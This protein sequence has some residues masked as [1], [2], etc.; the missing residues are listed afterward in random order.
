MTDLIQKPS[1]EVKNLY[2]SF[3][4]ALIEGLCKT[5]SRT[6]GRNLLLHRMGHIHS[7]TLRENIELIT[8]I[9]EMLDPLVLVVT[10]VDKATV[11]QR[12]TLPSLDHHVGLQEP[13]L[14]A[15][16]CSVLCFLRKSGPVFREIVLSWRRKRRLTC[17]SV[18][19]RKTE[20]SS[21]FMHLTRSSLVWG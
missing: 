5:R 21:R 20:H 13:L 7:I 1:I 10:I 2:V 14:K 19:G 11:K 18:F 8:E 12:Q 9:T 3:H 17:V 6:Q 16:N 4:K 15:G